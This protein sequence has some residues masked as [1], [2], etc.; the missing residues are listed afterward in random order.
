MSGGSAITDV[1]IVTSTVDFYYKDTKAGTHTI[2]AD[3]GGTLT[4]TTDITV[5]PDVVSQLVFIT[6][7][8]TITAGTISRG[9][10]GPDAGYVRKRRHAYGGVAGDRDVVV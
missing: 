2:T 10:D 6:P 9:H 1:D 4:A 3:G 5:E 7:S 8:R